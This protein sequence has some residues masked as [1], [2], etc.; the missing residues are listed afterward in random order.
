[1]MLQLLRVEESKVVAVVSLDGEC[2]ETAVSGEQEE[3]IGLAGL[4]P[5]KE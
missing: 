5:Q 3:R 2:W 4:R 1:M